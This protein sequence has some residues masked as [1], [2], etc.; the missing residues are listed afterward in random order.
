MVAMA[1]CRTCCFKGP[2]LRIRPVKK[3]ILKIEDGAERDRLDT[4]KGSTVVHD[5]HFR[6]SRLDHY[7]EPVIFCELEV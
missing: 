1:Y 3:S 2:R 5:S 4:T 6:E 7:F